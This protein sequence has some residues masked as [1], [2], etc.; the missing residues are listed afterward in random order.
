MFIRLQ[1]SEL[2]FRYMKIFHTQHDK[3]SQTLNRNHWCVLESDGPEAPNSVAEECYISNHSSL[4]LLNSDRSHLQ[5]LIVFLSTWLEKHLF[6]QIIFITLLPGSCLTCIWN[7]ACS[8][9]AHFISSQMLFLS[10]SVSMAH[11]IEFCY[12]QTK[13]ITSP[14][15]FRMTP[16][17]TA[18]CFPKPFPTHT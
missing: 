15:P 7:W 11:S 9:W 16:F 18:R 5:L 12:K 10:C 13:R 4:G 8:S 6:I 14:M 3:V 17:P 2:K 1:V